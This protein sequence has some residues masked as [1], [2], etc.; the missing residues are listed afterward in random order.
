[1]AQRLPLAVLLVLVALAV[2]FTLPATSPA[3]S[4]VNLHA[5]G[6]LKKA[7]RKA[8]KRLTDRPFSG[9]RKG[10]VYY[11]RCG[12]RYYALAS[13]K[14]KEG[15]YQDQPER[16]RRKK[17]HRWKDYGDTGGDG[18]GAPTP[19]KLLQLWGFDQC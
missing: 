2:A 3:S 19:R 15:G 1:M 14:D 17:H 10:S 11:G 18:C 12:S 16:F 7:L 9:P 6:K 13:F 5:T 8:H 4:C